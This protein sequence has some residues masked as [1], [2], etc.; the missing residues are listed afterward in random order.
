MSV[1]NASIIDRV[2]D[3]GSNDYQQ[4]IP[5]AV[6]D[7]MAA[8]QEA[9]LSPFNKNYWNQ[10]VTNLVT[11]IGTQYVN[12]LIWKNP[13]APFKK[14][15]FT[16]GKAH[17]EIGLDLVTA[18]AYDQDDQ[19]AILRRRGLD[20]KVANYFVNRR[21]RYQVTV[22]EP[23]LRQSFV[24]G[25]SGD[26][27]ELSQFL[28]ATINAVNISDQYDEYRAVLNS[29]AVA[30][31]R[32]PLYNEQVEFADVENPTET[33]VKTLSRKIR[34]VVGQMAVA[35]T[36]RYNAWGVPQVSLKSDLILIVTPAT[37][38]SMQ[39]DV[40]AD[41]FNMSQVDFETRLIVVDELPWAEAHAIL[42][43]RKAL[44]I[45]DDILYVDAFYNPG[46]LT[47]NYFLHHHQGISLSPMQ[48]VVVFS[49]A[50]STQI[51][52]VNV[53]VDGISAELENFDGDPVSSVRAGGKAKLVVTGE[54]TVDEDGEDNPLFR[55][56]D[57]WT[58]EVTTPEGAVVNTSTYVD[59]LGVLH[60]SES[61]EDG[62]ELLIKVKSAYYD[63]SAPLG[64]ASTPYEA[65]VTFTVGESTA[66]LPPPVV[67]TSAGYDVGSGKIILTGTN[68]AA[69]SGVTLSVYTKLG[70]SPVSATS[71]A[72][73]GGVLQVTPV[74][75]LVDGVYTIYVES[76]GSA[77]VASNTLGFTVVIETP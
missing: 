71:Q 21:V 8:V 40:L 27:N 37:R 54:G 62:T 64:T 52:V 33:E 25:L 17:Q 43:D 49:N 7:G 70:G 18:E 73:V 30:N 22:N 4:R 77:P 50:E 19:A 44:V 46:T 45:G 58:A 51:G 72:V 29:F 10:F 39:V 69:L 59:R 55:I 38:A 66:P 47:T 68:V 23:M 34:T 26:G 5:S 60:V 74:A 28:A 2:W 48:N 76:A 3:Y 36:K 63:P 42:A 32:Y 61:L 67:L 57:N 75:P 56:P 11:L 53:S 31:Q 6:E 65:E 12:Q 14:D 9:L 16:N 15:Y 1:N 20:P 24:G 35:P 41:A 13:F